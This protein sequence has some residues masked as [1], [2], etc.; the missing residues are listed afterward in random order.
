MADAKSIPALN[1]RDLSRFWAGVALPHGSDCMLWTAPVDP[2]GYCRFHFGGRGGCDRA[3]RISYVLAYGEP[4]L[5][6][7]LDHL[8]RNRACC[9][10]D[11]LEPVARGEN[12]RRGEAGRVWGAL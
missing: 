9:N 5:V 1:D 10:P 3:H 7:T 12:V 8:C 6:L 2:Y 11:H 4:D